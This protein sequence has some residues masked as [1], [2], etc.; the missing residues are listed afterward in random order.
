M[1]FLCDNCKAKYQIGDDRVAGK[2]VRMKCRRCGHLIEVSGA[3][4]STSSGAL[5]G[6]AGLG[7][8]A[9]AEPPL[10]APM[11]VEVPPSAPRLGPP[12][13]GSV[14]AAPGGLPPR[15]GAATGGAIPRPA[16]AGPRPGIPVRPTAGPSTRPAA[17]PAAIA[18]APP[19]LPAPAPASPGPPPLPTPARAQSVAGAPAGEEWYVGIDGSPFGP[20]P[21]AVVREKALAGLVDGDSLV[22]REGLDEWKPLK[23]VPELLA[24]LAEV[25]AVRPGAALPLLASPPPFAALP[26]LVAPSPIAVELLS[27]AAPAP[28]APLMAADPRA[29]Q[30]PS[31]PAAPPAPAASADL[32]LLAES[33]FSSS[34]AE[35]PPASS[36]PS[37]LATSPHPSSPVARLESP[38]PRAGT[39]PEPEPLVALPDELV[40]PLLPIRRRGT[41]PL[42]YAV[43]AMAAAFGGVSAY[44]LLTPRQP[45]PPRPAPIAVGPQQAAPQ[46]GPAEGL[47]PPPVIEEEAPAPAGSPGS[48]GSLGSLGS[49]GAPT[50]PGGS[51]GSRPEKSAGSA[52]AIDTSGFSNSGASGPASTAASSPGLAQLSQADI[53]R[54]VSTNS[55]GI[56]RRCWQPAL[57]SHAGLGPANARVMASITIA[58]SGAVQSASASGGERDFPGLASCIAAR[59]KTWK[60]APSSGSTPVN[61]PFVFAGQ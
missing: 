49:P 55:P 25:Q 15:P 4:E 41:S 2:M 8:A 9:D 50:R 20:V 10:S 57:E 26:P 32:D 3:P 1:L 61:I 18:P 39:A 36:P 47:P 53:Q 19:A 12:R 13:P 30:L 14:P 17:A 7:G 16:V 43:I 5:P 28:A 11:P 52:A 24:M 21:L 6:A 48:L 45:P 44:V 33:F 31:E 60:F 46:T 51:I 40:E 34:G 35:A 23:S 37:G 54:V 27:A 38:A 42:I 29:A 22:W 59:V 56:K 58:P